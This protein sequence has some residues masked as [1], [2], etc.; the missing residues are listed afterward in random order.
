MVILM[1]TWMEDKEW[2]KIRQRL[3]QGF[4]WKVQMTKRE[5]R[6]G[7]AMGGILMGIRKDLLEEG[8]SIEMKEERILMGRV[9]NGRKRWRIVGVYVKGNIEGTLQRLQQWM[10]GREIKVRTVIGGDFNARTRRE[11]GDGRR[12]SK[13]GRD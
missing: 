6:K 2:E 3:L 1:E 10:G 12:G 8:T 9:K 5:K 11:G 13:G 7:R 4:E